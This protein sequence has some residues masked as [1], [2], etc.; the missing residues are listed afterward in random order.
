MIICW[1]DLNFFFVLLKKKSI[2]LLIRVNVTVSVKIIVVKTLPLYLACYVIDGYPPKSVK[3]L[4]I[5]LH[6]ERKIY[7]GLSTTF[8]PL[9]IRLSMHLK[10]KLYSCNLKYIT[11]KYLINTNYCRLKNILIRFLTYIIENFTYY[12]YD[13]KSYN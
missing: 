9:S 8:E 11:L 5:D 7:V 12:S 6:I 4:A 13:N 3:S 1:C 10:L 2:P